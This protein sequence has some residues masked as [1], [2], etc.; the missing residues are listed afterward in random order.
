MKKLLILVIC[1]TVSVAL[2]SCGSTTSGGTRTSGIPYRAFVSNPVGGGV[3]IVNA[4][5][6][7]RATTVGAISA[8]ATPGMMV[9]TPNRAATLV[10]S[11]YGTNNPDDGFTIINNAKESSASQ[12][13]LPGYTESIVVSPDSSVAYVAVPIAKV[14]EQSEGV[15]EVI[16]VG[17]SN[18]GVPG[19]VVFIPRVRYLVDRQRGRPDSGVQ[20]CAV[21]IGNAVRPHSQLLVRG[22]A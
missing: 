8:G 14:G 20:R 12:L 4:E 9:V 2:V 11:G 19:G 21:L 10:Y 17:A 7:L 5:T 6:D 3:N 18:V 13:Q 22:Y 16:G 15:I 1:L